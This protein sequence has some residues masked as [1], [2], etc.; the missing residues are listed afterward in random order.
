MGRVWRVF[1][2]KNHTRQQKYEVGC[3]TYEVGCK[4][5]EVSRKLMSPVV[6]KIMG[7]GGG[8]VLKNHEVSCRAEEI[9]CRTEEVGR[10]TEEVS[11]R[12]EEV[13]CRTEEV[14]INYNETGCA[15]NFMGSVVNKQVLQVMLL[16]L[17]LSSGRGL[18]C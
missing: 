11:C 15:K 3:K 10:R 13:G 9:G 4:T 8:R 1:S 14:G 6:Q 18:L 2:V 7:S 16:W 5:Y 17:R 12:T